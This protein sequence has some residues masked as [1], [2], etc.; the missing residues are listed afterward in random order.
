MNVKKSQIKETQEQ[1]QN[2][3]L[4]L[5]IFRENVFPLKKYHFFCIV[6]P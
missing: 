3:A 5:I 2:V 4:L 1:S 6:R